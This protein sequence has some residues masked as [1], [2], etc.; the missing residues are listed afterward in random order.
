V[1]TRRRSTHAPPRASRKVAVRI[2]K[3]TSVINVLAPALI[4]TVKSV[5]QAT[6]N[7]RSSRKSIVARYVR[8]SKSGVRNEGMRRI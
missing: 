3:P 1:R 5:N 4:P 7:A 6:P 2:G 8:R